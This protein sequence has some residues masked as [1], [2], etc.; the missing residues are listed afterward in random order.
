MIKRCQTCNSPRAINPCQKCGSALKEPAKGW[1][2]LEIPDLTLIRTYC[3]EV[4]YALAIHGTLE[5][6]VDLIAAPW[7]T[8]AVGNHDLLL[9]LSE[10]LDANIVE[11]ERKPWGRYAATLQ[12]RSGW[13]KPIDISIAPQLKDSK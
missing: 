12:I 3:R 7:T 13:F 10:K 9:Y 5:R 8:D 11:I 4:G 1:T 6:D 2:E